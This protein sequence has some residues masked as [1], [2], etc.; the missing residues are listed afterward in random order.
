MSNRRQR[1]N[2]I[3]ADIIRLHGTQ[4]ELGQVTNIHPTRMSG[5]INGY[6]RP[7]ARELERYRA[8]MGDRFVRK[9]FSN[10]RE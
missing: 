3:R 6:I 9:Y 8:A 10:S 1:V 4:R 7:N 2:A 5:H